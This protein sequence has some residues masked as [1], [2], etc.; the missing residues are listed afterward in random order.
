MH[1]LRTWWCSNQVARASEQNVSVPGTL[2]Q[3]RLD[4]TE[5]SLR[6]LEEE[7]SQ[8][9]EKV[10]D[11]S[12]QLKEQEVE[13]Q[14]ALALERSELQNAWRHSWAEMQKTQ[15]SL[16]RELRELRLSSD[17]AMAQPQKRQELYEV[18]DTASA[19]ELQDLKEHIVSTRNDSTPCMNQNTSHWQSKTTEELHTSGGASA[20]HEGCRGGRTTHAR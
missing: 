8:N 17:E 18:L 15:D 16:R 6:G 13:H 12:E 9:R 14:A 4:E 10:A 2:F 19:E 11:L 1:F 5:K 3:T 20:R 7:N